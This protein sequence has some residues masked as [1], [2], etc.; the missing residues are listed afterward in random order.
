M[1]DPISGQ[2]RSWNMSRIR[3]RDTAPEVRLRSLLHRAG[4]RFRLHGSKLPGR[5]DIVLTR[6]RAVILVH[7][8]FWHRHQNCR[9]ATTP[10]TRR[11][12][13]QAKFDSNVTRDSRNEAAL[14]AAGWNVLVVWECELKA[15]SD[16]VVVR[17]THELRKGC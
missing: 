9:N 16:A 14:A 1:V 5:P 15:D 8:C 11:E 3:S 13:W 10:G 17:L 12:F 2:R 6:Y 4:F 7:G